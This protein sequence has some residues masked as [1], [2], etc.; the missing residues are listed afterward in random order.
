MITTVTTATM[1]TMTAASAA[2]LALIAILLLISLLI[3]RELFSGL[4]GVR[5]QRL[6][7][8]LNGAIMPLA[9]VC[10]TSMGFRLAEMLG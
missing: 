9:A 6:R 3:Q 10:I 4:R 5:A 8:V 7:T 1:A 2:S